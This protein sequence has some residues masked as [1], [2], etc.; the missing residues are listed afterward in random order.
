MPTFPETKYPLYGYS[1]IFCFF[2]MD[3]PPLL[4]SLNFLAKHLSEGFLVDS[5]GLFFPPRE[6]ETPNSFLFKRLLTFQGLPLSD[7]DD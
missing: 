7:V 5:K 6:V 3:P 1:N 2:L 4:L